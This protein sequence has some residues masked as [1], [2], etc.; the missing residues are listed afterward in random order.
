M[1]PFPSKSPDHRKAKYLLERHEL[2]KL[3][4]IDYNTSLCDTLRWIQS[5]VESDSKQLSLLEV[6]QE[7]S[8]ITLQAKQ[9]GWT[10][11]CSTL[12]DPSHQNLLRYV[13]NENGINGEEIQF[14]TGDYGDLEG[15]WKV[16][17]MDVVSSDGC[18]HQH[19]LEDLALLR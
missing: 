15:D 9:M 16:V 6:T 17:V 13:A 11:V 10:S 8:F 14:E 2:E 1:L 12:R 4:D 7:I 3:N 18:L 5:Q 19:A